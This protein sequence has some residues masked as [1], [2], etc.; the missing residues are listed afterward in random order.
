MCD[1]Q[2]SWK[3]CNKQTQDEAETRHL[4]SLQNAHLLSAEHRKFGCSGPDFGDRSEFEWND[5]SPTNQSVILFGLETSSALGHLSNQKA[6]KGV[7]KQRIHESRFATTWITVHW[8]IC[9][10]VLERKR[11]NVFM[12]VCK[13]KQESLTQIFVRHTDTLRE[14][15]ARIPRRA[16]RR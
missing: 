10:N 16:S 5:K 6:T 7:W 2:S 9:G 12:Q 4:Y 8:E 1:W 3:R 14:S 11:L 13:S 15:S